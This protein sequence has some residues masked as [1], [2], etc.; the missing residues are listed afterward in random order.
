MN[1]YLI[2][3]EWSQRHCVVAHSMGEAERIYKTKYPYTT[4]EKITLYSNYV[5]IQGTGEV[6]EKQE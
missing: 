3:E 5:L 2:G 6:E 1:V 4:L